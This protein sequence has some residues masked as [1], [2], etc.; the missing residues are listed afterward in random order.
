MLSCLLYLAV[1]EIR[2]VL[3]LVDQLAITI[4]NISIG[5]TNTNN[6]KYCDTVPILKKSIG[7]TANGNIILQY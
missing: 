1:R 5:N 6:K 3:V 2:E 4:S 7:N